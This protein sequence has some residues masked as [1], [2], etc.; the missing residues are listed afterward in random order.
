[1]PEDTLTLTVPTHSAKVNVAVSL[2]KT[3]TV[4][5]IFMAAEGKAIIIYC[6]IFYFVSIYERQPWDLN[7]T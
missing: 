3:H 1:M 6:C 4:S 2:P 5:V 7:Q